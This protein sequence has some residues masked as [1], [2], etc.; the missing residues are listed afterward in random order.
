MKASLRPSGRSISALARLLGVAAAAGLLVPAVAGA[1]D[2]AKSYTLFMGANISVG[3]DGGLYPVRDISGGSWVIGVKGQ[4]V[5]VSAN[6]GPISMKIT[7]LLKLTETSATIAGLKGERS[8][9][10]DNDPSVKLTRSLTRSADL[11]AG[12]HAATNQAS[13]VSDGAQ[14]AA[15]MGVNGAGANAGHVPA[16]ATTVQQVLSSTQSAAEVAAS[17]PGSDLF[18]RDS[19]SGAPGDFDALDVAFEISS[20]KRLSAPYIVLI[21]HFHDV[22]SA[23]GTSGNL[24]YAKALEPIDAKPAKV[25]FEQAGFPFGF[26]LLS[27]EIHLYD[28]GVEVATNA[29]RKR[30]ALTSDE[31]F[32]YVKATYIGAHR[33][34]TLPASPV[35]VAKLPADL[36]ER[37]AAGKYADT[38][39][40]RVSRDGLADRAFADAA[41]SKEI[42]DPYLE[43]VVRSIRFKPALA[44]GR[45]V[46]GTASL[47]LGRLRL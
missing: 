23:A 30:T 26:E 31:A 20:A 6:K 10:F 16:T 12:N 4:P 34:E 25:K 24:V 28:Q 1:Q 46:E 9:T 8:Y 3:Q 29:A 2:E 33:G 19:N 42:D 43:S 39:Y 35:M 21:T 36:H 41:C 44:E 47:N 7:P 13:A 17:S 37:L 45:P 40:V 22:A 5:V 38:I 11:N 27:L 15:A 18:F 32:D 14:A